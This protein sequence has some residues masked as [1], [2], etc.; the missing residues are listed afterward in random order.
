MFF[1]TFFI[2]AKKKIV[3]LNVHPWA[4]FRSIFSYINA[5]IKSDTKEEY[6]K[7]MGRFFTLY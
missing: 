7:T 1:K 5:N 4:L 6:I 2:I 3:I